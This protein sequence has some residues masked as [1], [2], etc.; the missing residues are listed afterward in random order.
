M[1]TA[2]GFTRAAAMRLIDASFGTSA[3]TAPSGSMKAH[4]TTTAPTESTA[5]TDLGSTTFPTFTM[6]AATN[7]NPP[8]AQNGS[9]VSVTVGAS[10]TVVGFDS[11]DS[12]GTPFRWQFGQLGA[13]RAVI[14]GDTL[15]F[16][17]NAL[18]LSLTPTP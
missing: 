18:Q 17:I 12:G 11:W 3:L 2:S 1:A 16:A 13:S 8:V 6:S 4:V 7:A 10:G 9:A 5:G 15:G 14:I